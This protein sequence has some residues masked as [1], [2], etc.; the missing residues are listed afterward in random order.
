MLSEPESINF[1]GLKLS[2]IDKNKFIN[3]ICKYITDNRKMVIFGYSLGSIRILNRYTI[4]YKFGWE[5]ADVMIIDGRGLYLLGKLLGFQF[6]DDLSIPE[7][8]RILL[9]I[10]DKNKFSILFLGTEPEINNKATENTRIKFKNIIVYDGI[11]G[12]FG[13]NEEAEIVNKINL[14]KPDILFVGISS[15]KKEEFITRWKE[16]LDVKIILLCGGVIDIFAGDK[17]QTPK[18]L[19]KIGGASFYRFIQE[20]NRLYKYFFP[21]IFFLLFSFLPAILYNVVI[22]RNKKFS[23]PAFYKIDQS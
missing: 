4:M 10:S 22:K 15:P 9:H 11:D 3:Q 17:R 14:A 21:F 16:K 20:P 2:A 7:L 1:Y 5:Q 23:I 19:K 8:S 18:W 6:K 12:F 13:K